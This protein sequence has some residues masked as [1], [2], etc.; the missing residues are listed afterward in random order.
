MKRFVFFS[1]LSGLLV[2][3]TMSGASV[4]A[5]EIGLIP[6][7]EYHH[8]G[9]EE[10]RWTRSRENFRKDL[11]FLYNND[12]RPIT[13][14]NFAAGKIPLPKGKK[15]VVITFDDGL[16]NQFN[17]LPT[18]EID[19]D[20]ALGIMEAFCADYPD[21][22]CT[23]IFFVNGF[24][25]GQKELIEKKLNFLVDRGYE[26]GN[27]T[28]SHAKL[29]QSPS[30]PFELGEMNRRFK[31]W[32]GEKFIVDSLA[33]PFGGMPQSEAN[34]S[35]LKS[36]DYQGE[37]YTIK[38]AFLVGAEPAKPA[39]HPDFDPWKIPRIQAVEEEWR[40]HFGRFDN[41]TGKTEEKFKPLVSDGSEF[42]VKSSKFFAKRIGVSL[43]WPTPFKDF[44][45][46]G[47]IPPLLFLPAEISLQGTDFVYEAKSD[48]DYETVARRFLPYT[49][50]KSPSFYAAEL[51]K[52]NKI[53]LP[54][55]G[56]RKMILP[57]MRFWPSYQS[58]KVENLRGVYLTANSVKGRGRS[59][60]EKLVASGGNMVVF[61]IK[62]GKVA[63][64][65]NLDAVRDLGDQAEA[66]YDLAEWVDYLH[67]R[68]VYA[69]GRLVAFKDGGLAARRRDWNLRHRFDGGPWSNQEGAIWLDPSHPEVKNYLR[70]I[71]LEA[72]DKGVDEIQFDYVRFPATGRANNFTFVGEAD[73][74]NREQVITAFVR[75]MK[76]AL[77]AAGAKIGVD[78]F[79]VAGW[80][81]LD[82]SIVGQNISALG[83]VADVI[84]PMIYPS[85]FGA[86]Y[87]G[88]PDPANDPYFFVGES[89]RKFI[90]LTENTKVEIRP[91]FQGFPLGVRGFGQDYMIK[92]KK[93]VNDLGRDAFVVWSPGNRY[94]VS[95]SILLPFSPL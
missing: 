44:D 9:S 17:Y 62:E 93:A 89:M 69:V 30:L 76:T 36:G 42:I 1:F 33:Y 59:I 32:L 12:Y 56:E 23:A 28:L 53:E 39:F 57:F 20:S 40:R 31:K 27:H 78:V 3:L 58:F 25:F 86:G 79:G 94:E 66:A 52:A 14:K 11:E 6:V 18:E 19:P 61:D 85:H 37:V 24:P 68:G 2:F 70:A 67:Y 29:A 74:F 82:A 7:L 8:I 50:F 72:A 16:R 45:L 73:G 90:K 91:W 26:L 77:N 83:E 65:S 81:A 22:G 13:V 47:F 60:V 75:E 48:E 46:K 80:S 5:A 38:T 41:S 35:L 15:P 34:W 64:R 10:S 49:P 92:Q 63:Y 51:E 4:R 21:F 55:P 43:S 71:V 95:W 87:N 84:Y 54:L 88:H